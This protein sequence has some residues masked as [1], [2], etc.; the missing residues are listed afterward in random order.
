M[1]I[2]NLRNISSI[3]LYLIISAL[4]VV[5][6]FFSLY[7]LNYKNYNAQ[8]NLGGNL[9]KNYFYK[10]DILETSNKVNI[11]DIEKN[12]NYLNT[13]EDIDEKQNI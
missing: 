4:S 3:N 7:L 10:N 12:E 2:K 6:L 1:K 11:D 9:N 8:A 13:D 5:S